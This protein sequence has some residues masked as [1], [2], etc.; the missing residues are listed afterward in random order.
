VILV[1]ALLAFQLGTWGGGTRRP[2][3]A[4]CSPDENAIK[5]QCVNFAFT[6]G[7]A[8]VNVSLE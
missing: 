1:N 3:H 2:N 7:N 4:Q 6:T 8:A 5:H